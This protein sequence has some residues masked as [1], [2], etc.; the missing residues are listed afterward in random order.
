MVLPRQLRDDAHVLPRLGAR[1]AVAIEHVPDVFL[2]FSANKKDWFIIFQTKVP[3][4]VPVPVVFC[5]SLVRKVLGS[6]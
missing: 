3:E 4:F 1:A 2:I 6:F 5:F